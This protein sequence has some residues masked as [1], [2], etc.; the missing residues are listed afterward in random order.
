MSSAFDSGLFSDC[1]TEPGERKTF[2]QINKDIR[3]VEESDLNGIDAVIHLA[4][5]R[6]IPWASLLAG[7]PRKR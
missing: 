2:P 7:H 4:G 5:S 1:F 3:D 6:T